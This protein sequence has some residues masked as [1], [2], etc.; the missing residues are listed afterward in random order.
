MGR[1][2]DSDARVPVLRPELSQQVAP[3]PAAGDRAYHSFM[4]QAGGWMTEPAAGEVV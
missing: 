1:T 3:I 2:V 4:S